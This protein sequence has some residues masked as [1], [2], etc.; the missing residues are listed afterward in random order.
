[1]FEKFKEN[2]EHTSEVKRLEEVIEMRDDEI[3]SLNRQQEEIVFVHNRDDER[4]NERYAHTVKQMTK[5]VEDKKTA[6]E[7][8]FDVKFRKESF[9]LEEALEAVSLVEA[10]ELKDTIECL[11]GLL[12]ETRVEERGS[13]QLAGSRLEIIKV[14]EKQIKEYGEMI[15][16]MA[17]KLPEVD[18]KK[19]NINVDVPASKVTV[20]TTK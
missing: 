7:L 10:D 17:T 20:K 2:K 15:K 12:N 19:F 14:Q 5:T 6:L 16:F 3:K 8:A 18:L 4:T 1:M 13:K 11:E 9:R